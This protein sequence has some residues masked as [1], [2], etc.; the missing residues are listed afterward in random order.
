MQILCRHQQ[1]V[2]GTERIFDYMIENIPRQ[3]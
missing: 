1:I 3:P 2:R